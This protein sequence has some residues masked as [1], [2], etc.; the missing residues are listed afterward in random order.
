M[1]GIADTIGGKLGLFG[2]DEGGGGGMAPP[3][4]LNYGQEAGQYLFGSGYKNSGGFA[5][6]KFQQ[7]IVNAERRMQSQYAGLDLQ[8]IN[9]WMQGIED[10]SHLEW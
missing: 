3:P 5:N 7:D 9:T 10:T 1:G 8:N 6:P 4:S 2:G